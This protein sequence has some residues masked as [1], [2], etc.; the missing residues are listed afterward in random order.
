MAMAECA[1]FCVCV[2]PSVI[3]SGIITS[4]DHLIHHS[5]KNGPPTWHGVRDA[6]FSHGQ[7]GSP[8]LV[9]HGGRRPTPYFLH[10]HTHLSTAYQGTQS[11][12][13]L[14]TEEHDVYIHR[15]SPNADWFVIRGFCL[16]PCTF[17]YHLVQRGQESSFIFQSIET[18]KVQTH[19]SIIQ[20]KT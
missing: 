20:R 1:Y 11:S 10:T 13:W 16:L 2:W 7:V 3:A 8:Q 18:H 6:I 4:S 9:L 17:S 15:V 14:S 5:Q 12:I 19:S